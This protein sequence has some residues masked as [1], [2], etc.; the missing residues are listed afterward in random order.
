METVFLFPG[1]FFLRM[2][3]PLHF[4][5]LDLLTL[6]G[7]LIFIEDTDRILSIRQVYLEIKRFVVYFTDGILEATPELRYVEDIVNL[8]KMRG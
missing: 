6:G 8:G 7:A 1:G 2:V 3:G 5:E 4:E